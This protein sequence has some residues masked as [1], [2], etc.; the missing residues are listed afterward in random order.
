MDAGAG[1]C[2]ES[3]VRRTVENGRE[4]IEWLLELG[5]PFTVTDSDDDGYTSLHLT[6]EGGHSHR[7]V[8]HA[9]DSTGRAIETTLVGQARAHMTT[10]RCM[11]ITS[12]SI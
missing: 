9:A 5:V 3:A 11:N 8:A 6:R 1:L 4:A 10:F 2:E 12:R 7:R